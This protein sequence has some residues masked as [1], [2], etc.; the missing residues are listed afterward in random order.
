MGNE[1]KGR[2]VAG[3]C[4]A[5]R[6]DGHKVPSIP[7][8]TQAFHF[9]PHLA[10]SHGAEGRGDSFRVHRVGSHFLRH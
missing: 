5:I 3:G 4:L 2:A 10:Y 8:P 6:L 9:L 7:L 1:T